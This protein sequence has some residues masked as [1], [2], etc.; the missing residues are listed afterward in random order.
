MKTSLRK[1]GRFTLHRHVDPTQRRYLRSLSQSDELAQASQD[2]DD[3][4]DCYDS[5]LS[6]AAATTNTAYEF[7][8][9][10]RE[11]GS[12]LLE[13]TALNDDEESGKVLLMLG[14]MQF[15]LQK[16]LDRYRS[17]ISRTITIPSQSLLNELRTVEEMKRQ[18]DEK[19]S[20]YEYIVMNRREKGKSRTVKGENF[21]MQQLQDAREQYDEEATLFVFRLKSLK[22]GQSRSLLT[23]A[24]RHHAAQLH[25]FRNALRSLEELEPHVKLVTE[26]QYI[27]YQLNGLEDDYCHEVDDDDDDDDSHYGDS[28]V[29]HDD[30]ELS[31]DYGQNGHIQ[32]DK[33]T[34]RHSMELDPADLTFPHVATTETV[35]ENL[36]RNPREFI[37]FSGDFKAYTQSAPLFAEKKSLDLADRMPPMRQSS[38]RKLQTYV[39]PTPGD[40]KSSA[41]T[42]PV[43]TFASTPKANL[44]AHNQMVWHSSPLDPPKYGKKSADE[45][46]SGTPVS[47]TFR[48]LKESN[49]KSAPNMLPSPLAEG[50]LFLQFDPITASSSKKFKRQAYSGPLTK[51]PEP[52]QP[53]PEHPQLYSGPILRNPMSQPLSSSPKASLISSSPLTSSP[54]ISE[55]HELPR[56]PA[57]STGISSRPPGLVGYS[58]PLVSRGPQDSSV[59]SENVVA[60]A[61]SPLP[62]PPSII[63]RSFS[64]PTSGSK[65][66]ISGVL[67]DTQNG[68]S[69]DA[70]SSPPLTPISL[71]NSRP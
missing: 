45:K 7:S 61:A 13:K 24:A 26:Q 35:K 62:R 34:L 46:Y 56:P 36:E 32:V 9:S 44:N 25:L 20:V 43:E 68:E 49:K 3:M 40:P 55:L 58:A 71:P 52:S 39:L 21:S 70:G 42:K 33:S 27:D 18:C 22:Q 5:L 54:K 12:C 59:K 15:E 65:P 53:L 51:K 37:A 64:I 4:R 6:A 16:L 60:G 17:H 1:L 47:N 63:S 48:I 67:Q 38:I 23:Q 30:G 41:S 11:L 66:K 10:L 14:K 57:S 2:L 28:Y 8:E 19:R 31:F 50:S 29:G 69:P